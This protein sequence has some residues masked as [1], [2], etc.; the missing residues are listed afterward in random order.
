MARFLQIVVARDLL[1]GFKA[2][3]N[4]SVALHDGCDLERHL[5]SF[6]LAP[7]LINFSTSYRG[8]EESLQ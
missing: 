3:H 7:T 5:K 8:T 2:F 1:T 6:T 4:F